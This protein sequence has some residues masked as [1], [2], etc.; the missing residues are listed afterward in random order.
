MLLSQRICF[1][2]TI[3]NIRDRIVNSQQGNHVYLRV[4]P[5]QHSSQHTA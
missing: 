1:F 4:R 3:L 5:L 2:C